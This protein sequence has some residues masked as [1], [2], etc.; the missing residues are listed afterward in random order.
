MPLLYWMFEP[1]H[2]ALDIYNIHRK[3]KKIIKY[4]TT[5]QNIVQSFF[6]LA[7]IFSTYFSPSTFSPKKF[8]HFFHNPQDSRASRA[9]TRASPH[10]Q[11]KTKNATITT[12]PREVDNSN[13]FFSTFF[14]KKKQQIQPSP[15]LSSL[16]TIYV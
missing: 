12:T 13:T 10:K 6:F 4:F 7:N 11:K 3:K 2:T 5:K 16:R 8:S 1:T 14:A 9:T 15:I